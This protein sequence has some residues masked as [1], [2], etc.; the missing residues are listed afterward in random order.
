MAGPLVSCDDSKQLTLGGAL[1]ASHTG[2]HRRIRAGWH[3][4]FSNHRRSV[5]RLGGPDLKPNQ[6]SGGATGA[7]AGPA[8]GVSEPEL[9]PAG[10]ATGA[11]AASGAS[12]DRM[13]M[14][15]PVS[16]AARRAF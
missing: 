14:R 11:T 8:A 4:V 9:E 10:G 12:S 5:Y 2:A 7:S 15:Q 3:A 1:P 13:S 6:S 16:R